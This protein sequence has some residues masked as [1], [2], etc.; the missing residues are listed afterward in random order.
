MFQS[1]QQPESKKGMPESAEMSQAGKSFQ[2]ILPYL[3]SGE[4]DDLSSEVF[5]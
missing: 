1:P 2:D 5:D 3:L 4:S